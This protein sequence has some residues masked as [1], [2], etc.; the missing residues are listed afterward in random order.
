MARLPSARPRGQTDLSA[1]RPSLRQEQQKRERVKASKP[2]TERCMPLQA[3]RS[4]AQLFVCLRTTH[5]HQ[6][7][8]RKLFISLNFL[9]FN[10]E[11]SHIHI[12]IK[13]T[14]K[15]Q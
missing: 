3:G 12:H 11:L 14:T 6:Y 13:T 15:Q 10:R 5:S 1:I 2:A 7:S 8:H 4:A 9:D